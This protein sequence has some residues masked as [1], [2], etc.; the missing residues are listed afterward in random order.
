MPNEAHKEESPGGWTDHS[1][2]PWV[3][4]RVEYL[5]IH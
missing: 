4:Y 5:A 1:H 2:G 3:V